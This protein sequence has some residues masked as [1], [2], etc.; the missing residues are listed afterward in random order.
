MTVSYLFQ[1]ITGQKRH[2][3]GCGTPIA[4]I[5][6][7]T[8]FP[9]F[10]AGVNLG[11]SRNKKMRTVHKILLMLAMFVGLSAAAFAQKDDPKKPPP[12]KGN[13]PVVTPGDKKPP[14]GDDKPKKPGMAFVIIASK[15]SGI[16]LA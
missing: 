13:P 5:T 12:P 7:W 6:M 8:Y 11:K 9:S 14:K 1:P 3:D 2:I 4:Y 10:P 16:D 15:E